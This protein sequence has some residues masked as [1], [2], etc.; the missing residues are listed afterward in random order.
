MKNELN[1]SIGY[2]NYLIYS[3]LTLFGAIILLTFLWPYQFG[4]NSER[5]S[6]AQGVY[7]LVNYL[8]EWKYCIFV[9]FIV[10]FLVFRLRKQIYLCE[11]NPSYLI[12]FSLLL[13][14]LIIYWLG[15]KIDIRYLGFF[16]V[17]LLIASLILILWGKQAFRLLFFPWL[18]LLFAWPIPPL[19]NL[20]S[21]PLKKISATIAD[22]CLNLIRISTV[23]SGNILLS[24]PD[25][26]N[27]L[28]LGERFSLGIADPCSGINSL[29][30]MIMLSV[31]LAYRGLHN[32]KNRLLLILASI[33]IAVI[34]NFIRI[35]LLGIFAYFL[36]QEF[37]VGKENDNGLYLDSWFHLFMG[38]LTFIIS[39]S[40]ILSFLYFLKQK[41][42]AKKSNSNHTIQAQE[43]KSTTT[44]STLLNIASTCLIW[45]LIAVTLLACSKFKDSSI[46]MGPNLT[47]NPVPQLTNCQYRALPI[48]ASE[49][50]ALEEGVTL[51][52]WAY[53]E[54]SPQPTYP[55]VASI[56]MSGPIKRSLHRPE[57]CLPSQG[58]NILSSKVIEIPMNKTNSIKATRLEL[59]KDLK[60]STGTI[61]QQRALQIY[62][63]IGHETT[64]PSY[65]KHI[66]KSYLDSLR[67]NIS[68]RWGMV[69]FFSQL[70]I[71][72][73]SLSIFNTP[74]IE[75]K[76]ISNASEFSKQIQQ[77]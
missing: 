28:G 16:S 72:N 31:L 51:S 60:T 54:N 27:N 5:N 40:A 19:D 67:K 34:G 59:Y 58:W 42:P 15:Y 49:K 62:Y 2:T 66:F 4:H 23:Q 20:L 3:A 44:S 33:P 70:P 56:V 14:A 68:H 8:P 36:G 65:Q 53:T 71:N 63:Y 26:S 73:N 11:F 22:T 57:V 46:P 41:E 6:I 37:A 35:T 39:I 50:Q 1:Q 17:H 64:T 24:A 18:L 69:S 21:L 48:T 55:T 10:G 76:L 29:Y 75:E 32:Q 7:Y 52:R 9:P 25:Q 38:F 43:F 47:L 61:Q 13:I 45:P 12:G 30:T 74:L 77:F